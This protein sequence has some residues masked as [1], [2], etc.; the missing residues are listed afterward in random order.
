MSALSGAASL[1]R[2]HSS[3]HVEPVLRDDL[4]TTAQDA[5]FTGDASR[6]ID[7]CKQAVLEHEEDSGANQFLVTLLMES[8]RFEDGAL[9]D[10]A[11]VCQVRLPLRFTFEMCWQRW[12]LRAIGG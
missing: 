2:V 5:F 12:T 3:A 7:L 9:H 11:P 10:V 6:A 8:N 1:D 4:L